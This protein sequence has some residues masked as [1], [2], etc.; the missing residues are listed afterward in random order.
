MNDRPPRAL[1][2]LIRLFPRLHRERYGQ[3]M[4]AALAYRLGQARGTWR[5]CVA[6]GWD[7]TMAA[8]GVW[9]D[10]L[11]EGM[12]RM[13]VGSGLDARF[14]LRSLWRARGYVATAVL[15]LAC[16]VAVNATVYSYVRGTLLHEPPYPDADEIVI[17]WG[18]NVENGQL[19]DVISGPSY[20][21]LQEEVSSLSPVAAFHPDGTYVQHDGPPEVIDAMEVTVGFFDVLR[22]RPA[23]GRL[24]DERDRMSGAGGTVVVTWAY[25]RDRLGAD[26]GVVGSALD[27]E[28][29][30]HTVIGVLPEGFEFISPTPL[31]T[32]IRDD[33]LAADP[34]GRIHYHV[35]GRLAPGVSLADVNLELARVMRAIVA[36]HPG[37][38]GW[39]FLAERLHDV[40]VE[41]VRPV[42][43][44]LTVTVALVLLV[45]LVNLATLF[46]IRAVA[47]DGELAVR[48]ALGAGRVTLT[49]VLAFETVG[50][51]AAGAA[52]GLAAVP[53]L[54][55]RVREMVPP[56]IPIPDSA[57]RVPVLQ[58]TLDPGVVAVAC[59]GAVLGALLLNLPALRRA[60]RDSVEAPGRGSSTRV[61][62]GMR[63]TRLL[64]ASELAIA[65]VLCLGAALSARS[66]AAL[67]SQEVGV[68]A[69][70]MLAL[71]LGDVWGLDATGRTEYFRAAVDAVER[72]PGVARAG[73]IDYVDFFA[74]DDYARVDFLDRAFQ[75]RSSI[76]EEW[77][78]V[79]EGAFQAA[80]MPIVA[81]RGF[82]SADFQ[83]RALNAVVNEAFAA[84]H[85]PEGTAVGAYLST[86]DSAYQDM[87]I[88]GVVGDVRSLG[89]AALP[90]P[91]LYVPNQG[92][93]RGHVGM[94]VRVAGGDPMALAGAV[95]DAIWA[96]DSSQPIVGPWLMTDLVG[97]WVAIPRATR[98]LVLA[99]AGLAWLLS[100]VGVF[101]VV[102][103]VVRTRRGEMGIRLALGASP[104]RLETD[105]LRQ[106]LPVI[107]AGVGTG[108]VLGVLGGRWARSILYGVAPSDALSIGAAV[109]AMAGATLLATWL[110]AR[111]AGR[112]D[113]TEVIR[114]E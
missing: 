86:H 44:V 95:R 79:D 102:A 61:H 52:I 78:R 58:A 98:T 37:W 15:V 27:L 66:A 99:L 16:A 70:G 84:K 54:L 19:R 4:E 83:G 55:E 31:Y 111:R 60:L 101:G 67:L 100:A 50:I 69:D 41:G 97:Q 21:D 5:A 6:A 105:Q 29:N 12:M 14:V 56:W 25:W 9:A 93:P 34:R 89:P 2:A 33:V 26:P 7:L 24:F 1:R 47:R 38:E 77:R 35:L 94:Y 48:A 108:L 91:M 75:A 53:Y 36:E 45:A 110:P 63:G 42:I 114:A 103:Y 104:S 73:V 106:I 82:A 81:G 57:A 17:V 18:S 32:P 107:V 90:P 65:T 40:S 80:G 46:R 62:A 109:I 49:R 43:V 76:R 39:S 59:G 87:T 28:D 10:K 96:V 72:V 68:E 8:I 71:N 23:M 11:R 113:P 92:N 3:E 22:V 20:I 74:E 64:V 112:I 13:M 88:V 51:A 85:Y 30:P